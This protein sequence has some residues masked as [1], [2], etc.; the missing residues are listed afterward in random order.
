MKKVLLFV[1]AVIFA[2]TIFGQTTE[3]QKVAVYITDQS[4]LNIGSFA[5]HFLV[6]AI[7][8]RGT[9]TAIE[10]TADFLNELSKEQS[11]QRSGAVDDGQISK[12]GKY[13]GVHLVCVVT[14]DKMSDRYFMVARLVDVETTTVTNSARPQKF[15]DVEDVETICESVTASLFGERNRST[16]GNNTNVQPNTLR[17]PAEPEMVLVQ[18]G[19]FIMGCTY[20]QGSDC[21][22]NEKPNH[23]VTVS[24][25]YIGKYEVTQRQWIEIM[26]NNPSNFKGDNLPV[27][28]VSWNEVQEFITRLN[29]RTGQHYRLPT[30]AEW[31]YAARGGNQSK[32]YKYSGSNMILDVAWYADNSGSKT[33]PVGTKQPNELGIYDMS[34][35]VWEWCYDWYGDYS[36]SSQTDPIGASSGSYRVNRGGSWGTDAGSVR[37][38]DRYSIAPDFRYFSIGFRLARSSKSIY[39]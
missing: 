10:R 2:G 14:V 17:N 32:K 39:F 34:G 28:N 16:S 31:E 18:G 26:S 21:Y 3:K 38:S 11:Y 27:E 12:L 13:F 35:N 25:F 4:Q 9:Y 5:G 29:E 33:H 22:D 36:S 7:V 1:F 6:N 15:D 30:E 23:Q 37:V 24:D 8:K 20:E 19:A